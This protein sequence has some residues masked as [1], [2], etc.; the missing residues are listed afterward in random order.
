MPS[1][2]LSHGPARSYST[3]VEA[4]LEAIDELV[5][6][7]NSPPVTLDAPLDELGIDDLD[8]LDVIETVTEDLGERGIA[9]IDGSELSDCKTVGDFVALL[10]KAARIEERA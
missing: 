6:G 7:R 2:T 3:L 8:L 4:V 5:G 9:A 10:A 1:E